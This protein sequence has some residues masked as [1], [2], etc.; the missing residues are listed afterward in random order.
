MSAQG[1]LIVR[2]YTSDAW[3]P[4]PGA[5]VSI[6][7]RST[8]GFTTLLGLRKTDESGFTTPL[9]VQT[10]DSSASLTPSD[11]SPYALV[12]ITCDHPGYEQVLIENAQVFPGIISV[13]NIA[14]LPLQ[15]FPDQFSQTELIDIPPQNL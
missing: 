10:P 4:V 15:A 5:V 9:T 12:D 14:L 6:S 11:T 7:Q 13:Q 8:D 2:V 1:T 3:I